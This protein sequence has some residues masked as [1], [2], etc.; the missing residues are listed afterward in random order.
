MRIVTSQPDLE[1]LLS[2]HLHPHE[3]VRILVGETRFTAAPGDYSSFSR[4]LTIVAESTNG[5]ART[6]TLG[7]LRDLRADLV[8]SPA[9]IGDGSPARQATD[10]GVP[11]RLDFSM[12]YDEHVLTG[13]LDHFLHSPDLQVPIEPFYALAG[14]VGR[15][16]KLTLWQV[17]DSSPGRCFFVDAERRISLSPWWARQ[18]VF[19]GTPAD[20]METMCRSAGWAQL[21]A[22]AEQV[23]ISQTPCA[24]CEHYPYCGG[25]WRA[26]Q[27]SGT[28]CS[29][30]QRL[31][32]RMAE[33]YRQCL[34]DSAGNPDRERMTN[35]ETRMS[36]E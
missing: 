34:G 16:R 6:A 8:F 1:R 5:A 19:F 23:F 32:D 3:Q 35:D 4:R 33:A 31:M 21:E 14:A 2:G 26:S 30:W 24:F 29:I 11:V 18:A 13:L 28:A 25:I 36:K 15:H 17:F 27:D 7:L 20:S 22:S 12:D 10:A 9:T